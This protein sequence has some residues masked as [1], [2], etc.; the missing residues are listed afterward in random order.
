MRRVTIEELYSRFC[1][2]PTISTDTRNIGAKSLFFALKGASFDGNEFAT[3]ALEMGAAYSVIDSIDIATKDS[4]DRLLLVDDVLTALQQLAQYHRRKLGIE[5]ISITGSNGK[6]TTKEL[7]SAVLRCRYNL[8]ATRGNLNNHIG[9]PLTLLEIRPEHNLAIVEMGAS[10]C[11]EIELLCSIAEP[12]YGL[13]TN[14]GRAHLEGFEGEEGVKRGKGE[15]YDF[16]AESHGKAFVAIE[17][18]ATR[19]M[20]EMRGQRLHTIEYRYEIA[21][22]VN[23]QLEGEY[24]IYNV[25]AAIAVGDYFGIDRTLSTKAIEGYRPQNNRSQ[26][27]EGEHNILIVDCYNANPSSMSAAITNIRQTRGTK[28][29]ILGD[30]LELGEWAEQEHRAVIEQALASGS[31]RIYLVGE[32]FDRVAEGYP[33][34]KI[35][36]FTDCTEL[37]E[38]LVREQPITN[39][40][41]LIKGSRGIALERV[42]E[43]LK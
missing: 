17:D 12:N 33:A 13:I 20:A 19:E 35:L 25:A 21:D 24:N 18:K 10:H 8:H 39:S 2:Y 37:I 29:L 43:K 27:V 30:M 36:S 40:T 32:I 5:I 1:Q 14:I 4:D 31:E 11:H 16:L 3:K 9:V 6:T 28:V 26:R 38:H 42:I 15:L 22:G 41:I 34:D 7:L 23:H